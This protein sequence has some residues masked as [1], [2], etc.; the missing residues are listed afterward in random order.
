MSAAGAAP[1]GVRPDQAAALSGSGPVLQ[2]EHLC[3]RFG[4]LVAINDLSFIARRGEVTALW[5]DRPLRV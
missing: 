1:V 3:M 4:G 5:G 2:V